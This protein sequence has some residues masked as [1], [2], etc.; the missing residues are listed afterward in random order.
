MYKEAVRDCDDCLHLDATNIKAMLR[1]SDALIANGC[2]N[3]AYKQYTNILSIDPD[4][5]IA[6]KSLQNISLRYS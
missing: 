3:E 5:E 2:K 4:N 6:K 1:K